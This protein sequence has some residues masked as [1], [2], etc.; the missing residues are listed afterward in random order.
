M[1]QTQWPGLG[2]SLDFSALDSP[3]G[4]GS[5]VA[6]GSGYPRAQPPDGITRPWWAS[7]NGAGSGIPNA[8]GPFGGFFGNGNAA[9]SSI[10]GILTGLVSLL[11][12]LIGSLVNQNQSQNQSANQP[13]NQR[14]AANG[15]QAF[16]NLDV[17]STGDPHLAAVGT[18]EGTGGGS[19][20]DAHWD[21][22]SSQNDLVHSTQIDGGYRVSTAVTQ[23]GANGVTWNQSATVH[24]N[25]DQDA[26]TMN[27][28]GSFGIYDNGQEVRLGK[29]ESATL[30]GGET[31]SENED[32]SLLVSARSATGGTISTTLRANG[33]GV[34]VTT[35]AHEIAVGGD[36][37]VHAGPTAPVRHV[38]HVPPPAK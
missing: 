23:P 26:V 30:S 13:Q 15:A 19:A 5:S 12:Q 8:P 17:S 25:F 22:M 7:G 9:N 2:S 6:I 29:G 21:S 16:E 10:G 24:A 38:P 37:I 14:C 1:M 32:G 33:Q 3:L 31:V 11:Q 28:D 27:R 34:D 36:A 35:H 20:V 18:R 4:D